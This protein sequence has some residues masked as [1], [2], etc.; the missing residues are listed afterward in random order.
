MP[1]IPTY[2][3]DARITAESP[4]LKSSLQLS[5]AATPAAS[6]VPFAEKFTEYALRERMIVDKTESLKLEN[7]STTEYKNVIMKSQSFSDPEEAKNYLLKNGKEVLNKYASKASNDRVKKYFASSFAIEENKA[8][9]NVVDAVNKN[10]IKSRTNEVET[11]TKTKISDYVYSNSKIPLNDFINELMLDYD[12][13]LQDGFIN[14]SD[15]KA[16]Q[17]ELIKTV[18]FEKTKKLSGDNPVELYKIIDDPIKVPYLDEKQR[19]DLKRTIEQDL[20]VRKTT[21]DLLLNKQIIDSSNKYGDELLKNKNKGVNP[22]AIDELFS[23]NDQAKE[24][25]FNLNDR[26]LKNQIKK[27]SVYTSNDTVIKKI[28]NEE[29]KNDV[30]DFLLDNETGNPQSLVDRV[31]NGTISL[32]DYNFIKEIINTSGKDEKAKSNIK[33]FFKFID[34]NAPY[35]QGNSAFRFLDKEYDNRLIGFRNEMYQEYKSGIEKGIPHKELLSK[36]S[37]NFIGKKIVNFLPDRETQRKLLLD[38]TEA[39]LKEGKPQ[40]NPGESQADFLKRTLY[41]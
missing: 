1:K 19:K 28:L 16:T 2:T 23:F 38:N 34:D 3:A 26:I 22:K 9:G 39:V 14:E 13:M 25:M 4:S 27:D 24:K 11:K 30:E 31:G 17:E 33:D 35:V 5:P 8:L 6:L 15:L 18:I 7:E 29:I 32:N 37:K 12:S 21:S 40:R 36:S 20:N 10:L 41:K